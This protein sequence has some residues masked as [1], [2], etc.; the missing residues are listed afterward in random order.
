[1]TALIILGL[2]VALIGLLGCVLPL[3]PG[4]PLSFLSLI[5]L[6]YAK[7]WE[8]FRL[9][10]L[11][12]MAG[13][14]IAVTISEYILPIGGAKRYGASKGGIWLSIAGMILGFFLFPPWGMV[15]GAV[16]GAF[17]GEILAGRRA[18][19]ALRASWGVVLG[20]LL[21]IG[22][23]IALCGIMLFFYVKE[24]F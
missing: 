6:S 22:L 4:P 9:A 13:M 12:V 3:I 10:F 19:E 11:L 8:P 16:G 1:M 14:T 5:I 2:V 17:I 23:K 20:N 7:G 18:K 24:M 21:V 15:I